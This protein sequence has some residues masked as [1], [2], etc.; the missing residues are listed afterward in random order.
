MD[1]L[2]TSLNNVIAACKTNQVERSNSEVVFKFIDAMPSDLIWMS[3]DK[4]SNI[5]GWSEL[6]LQDSRIIDKIKKAR[7]LVSKK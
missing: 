7:E 5:E 2:S 1:L 4:L 3:I 6:L